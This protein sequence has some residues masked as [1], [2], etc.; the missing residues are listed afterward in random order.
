MALALKHEEGT[1]KGR[2]SGQATERGKQRIHIL[3]PSLHRK[4]GRKMSS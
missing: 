1:K 3:L 4:E 2:L